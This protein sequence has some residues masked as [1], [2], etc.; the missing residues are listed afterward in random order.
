MS[1]CNTVLLMLA[2]L[3]FPHASTAH[4]VQLK[5]ELTQANTFTFGVALTGRPFAYRRDGEL[6]GFEIAMARGVAQAHGLELRVVQLPRTQLANALASGE[7]DA[8]NTFALDG[9]APELITARYLVV[10]DH[11]MVL[12]GNP[13]RIRK[14]ADLTGRTVAVTAG[15][16]AEHFARAINKNLADTGRPPMNI[17]S[18]PD[19]RYTHVP[20]S[21]GHAVAYFV[22]TVSAVGVTQ[23]PDARVRLVEGSFQPL[24]EVGFGVRMGNDNIWH[25]VEHAVAAMVATGNYKRLRAKYGLPIDLSPYR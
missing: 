16:T 18:F 21:I 9:D 6:Q 7:V 15:S 11:L 3:W 17:H 12:K 13:F 1:H 14:T 24:R 8:I 23:D 22:Q 25:A 4:Y 10:G 2:L 20:V 19:Q 5:G